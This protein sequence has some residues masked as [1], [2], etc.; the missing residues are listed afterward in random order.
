MFTDEE[1]LRILGA[2]RARDR[3]D[4]VDEPLLDCLYLESAFGMSGMVLEARDERGD[5][6]A[7]ERRRY[8][9][10]RVPAP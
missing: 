1:L 2:L 6:I 9:W 4:S 7:F 3:G 8:K 5:K 10:R